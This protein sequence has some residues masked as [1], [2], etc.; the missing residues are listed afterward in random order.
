MLVLEALLLIAVLVLGLFQGA[1]GAI[2]DLNNNTQNNVVADS[3]SKESSQPSEDTQ[4]TEE[5]SNSSED[6]QQ[7]DTSST[8]EDTDMWGISADYTE[9]RIQFSEKA[10]SLLASLTIEQKVAQLFLITP[11]KHTGYSQ[12]TVFGS[13]SKKSFDRCPVGGFVYGK[14]NFQNKQQV[15]SLLKKAIAYSQSKLGIPVFTAIE[16]EGGEHYLPLAT[17]LKY[18]K[19]DLASTLAAQGDSSLVE[20]SA[21]HRVNYLK[22]NAFNLMLTTV[23]DIS[24]TMD[25]D[26][27]LRTYGTDVMSVAEMVETDIGTIE[28]AGLNATLKYFPGKASAV[29]NTQGILED[30]QTQIQLTNGNLVSYQAGIDAGASFVMVA[31]VITESVTGDAKV[32]CTLSNKTVGLLREVM[33]FDGVIITDNFSDES[34]V[35]VYGNEDACVKAIQAGMD[36]IYMPKDF[37]KAYQAVLAAV[38]SGA[39]TQE[40][41]D[42][43]VGRILTAKGI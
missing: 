34:F 35:S 14:T 39:I 7:E 16:E 2:K 40:R 29:A 26:Y 28:G 24:K 4:N 18:Q 19:T 31:N 23:A 10:E 9:D 25:T 20:K 11:E 8:E 17:A 37:N 12:V 42:N 1:K 43:A 6:T 21:Q 38:K 13:T 22:T 36:M 15:Q 3:E 5:D 27:A 41:L 33:G 30:K 32:P